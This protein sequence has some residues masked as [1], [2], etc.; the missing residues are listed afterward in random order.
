MKS[1]QQDKAKELFFQTNLSKKEIAAKVGVNRKT[2]LFWSQQGN[3]DKLRMSSRTMPSLIAEKCYYLID[4][5]AN[6]LLVDGM[7][8]NYSCL[9][10]KHA[11]TI[12]LLA[13]SIKKLKNRSTVNESMEMFNFFLDGVNRRD[14]GLAE[15]IAPMMEEYIT[16]RKNVDTTDSLLEE[17]RQDGTLP[18]PEK[19]INENNADIKA[20][21]ELMDDF[22]EFIKTRNRHNPP[23]AAAPPPATTL[24][25]KE[26]TP[27][28]VPKNNTIPQLNEAA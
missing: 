15:Q 20:T 26:E 27:A 2:I 28:E 7:S 23:Q 13:S 6:S 5:Y 25:V 22:E 4:Q 1:A 19:E 3:W 24:P 8:T 17:F 10:L 14:P 9:Q 11:Q 18:Y 16:I 12:H 21:Q